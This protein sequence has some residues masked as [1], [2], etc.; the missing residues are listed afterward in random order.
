M[1]DQGGKT[2]KS[3]GSS[4]RRQN[5][6]SL[7][8]DVTNAMENWKEEYLNVRFSSI[9]FSFS[10]FAKSWYFFFRVMDTTTPESARFKRNARF[11]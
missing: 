5:E 6:M 1:K 2:I 10:S 8:R 11:F 7:V 3:A 4:M 9:L